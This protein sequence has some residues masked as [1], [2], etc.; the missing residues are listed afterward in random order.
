MAS[1]QSNE[2]CQITGFETQ[3]AN[4]GCPTRCSR[5]AWFE[6]L[7]PGQ[8]ELLSAPKDALKCV[9]AAPSN[10]CKG[11]SCGGSRSPSD[12][13]L[14]GL[15]ILYYARKEPGTSRMQSACDGKCC[16]ALSTP[17]LADAKRRGRAQLRKSC[18]SGCPQN[19]AMTPCGLES[20]RQSRFT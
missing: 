11:R 6:T 9:D 2:R 3:V 4:S 1:V 19:A 12:C 17:K 8:N 18:K 5:R 10:D 14:T 13:K 7:W 20:E 15:S 16:P